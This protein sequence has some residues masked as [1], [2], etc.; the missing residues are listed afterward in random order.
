MFGAVSSYSFTKKFLIFMEKS[1]MVVKV[2]INGF[3]RIGR[4]A[5]RR[6]QNEGVEVHQRPYRSSYA[7]TCEIRYNSR[8]V[9][10]VL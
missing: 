2:G 10:T 6:I 1:R 5:F 3:G 9:S 7:C 4:L 8:S